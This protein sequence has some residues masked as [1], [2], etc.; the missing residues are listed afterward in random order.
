M[1]TIFN[2]LGGFGGGP[3]TNVYPQ[4]APTFS[5]PETLVATNATGDI[6]LTASGT[7]I[8][9][10]T[11]TTAQFETLSIVHYGSE[12]YLSKLG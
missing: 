11:A 7:T 4:D 8:N 6:S 9:G 10:T 5:S 3:E 1:I 2:L 12:A